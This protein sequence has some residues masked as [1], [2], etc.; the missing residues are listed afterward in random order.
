MFI[1]HKG[2]KGQLS[3][4]CVC[5]SGQT[6]TYS[7][8]V[9]WLNKVWQTQGRQQGPAQPEAG[10][11]VR[12]WGHRHRSG[13]TARKAREMVRLVCSGK[14]TRP[15]S[16]PNTFQAIISAELN[17]KIYTNLFVFPSESFVSSQSYILLAK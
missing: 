5:V 6:G 12:P 8:V 15:G 17:D 4:S 13:L 3:F 7:R 2:F 9:E 16:E 1:L 11:R 14:H 10:V